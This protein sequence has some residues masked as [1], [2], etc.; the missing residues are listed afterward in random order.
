MKGRIVL[1]LQPLLVLRRQVT[2]L[3]PIYQ[4]ES[5]QR[6]LHT[7]PTANLNKPSLTLVAVLV[8][9]LS[10]EAELVLHLLSI[11]EID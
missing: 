5:T 8:S 4:I 9:G 7:V 2:L 10:M 11:C 6:H 3:L 1:K